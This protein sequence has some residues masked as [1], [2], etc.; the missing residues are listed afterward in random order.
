MRAIFL[1][2]ILCLPAIG[3]LVSLRRATRSN[4]LPPSSSQPTPATLAEPGQVQGYTLTPA[5]EAQAIAY[6]SARDELYF[7][8]VA[9]GLLL[10]VLLLQLRVAPCPFKR[11]CGLHLRNQTFGKQSSLLRSSC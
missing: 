10:L 7:I 2:V 3:L 1:V 8:D 9:Y 11:F 6:A 5:Q 4:L